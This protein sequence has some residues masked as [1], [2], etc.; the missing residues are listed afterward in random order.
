MILDFSKAFDKVSH[1]HLLLKLEH[2]GVRG[3]TLSWIGDFLTN[4][5]Q[6]VMIEGHCLM[7]EAAP[8]TP[9]VPQGSVLGPL[10]LLCYINYLPACVSSHISLFAD[11]CLLYRTI[12]V[13]HDGVILQKYLNICYNSGKLNGL[14]LTHVRYLE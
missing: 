2:Y 14:C 3:T 12:H 5:T 8:V 10:L 7:S 11:G 13:Q 1:R 4:R 6:T 9:G